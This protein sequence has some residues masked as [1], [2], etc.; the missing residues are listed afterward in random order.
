M[1]YKMKIGT[2]RPADL[3]DP[4]VI[5]TIETEYQTGVDIISLYRAWNRCC[6]KDD[7]DWLEKLKKAPKE[8][9]LTW[10]P[11]NIA[12]GNPS[13]NQPDF[14]LKNIISK[15]FDTYI[16][17][18]AA[19]LKHFPQKVYF[20]PM[21]EM[22]GDWYPWCGTAN[23][24]KPSDFIDAWNHIRDI[25]SSEGADNLKWVWSPYAASYPQTIS[26]SLENYFPGDHAIDW[27]GLDGYN[28]GSTKEWSSWQS[29]D[30]LFFDAYNRLGKLTDKPFMIAE[31]GCAEQG[32]HKDIWIRDTFDALKSTYRKINILIWFDVNKECDWRVSSS[33]S[34]LEMFQNKIKDFKVI[35]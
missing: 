21:H 26:N 6:I 30:A 19:C 8:I 27:I 35:E 34:S 3:F 20:R 23:N 4:R 10:E 31:T 28:W 15:E 25:F 18:F 1:A 16:K 24:N 11:W 32:G 33:R 5:D 2:Y 9:L 13:A 7:T 29:F 22:N 17:D 14:S 12:D